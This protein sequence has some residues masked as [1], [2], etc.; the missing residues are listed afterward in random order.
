MIAFGGEALEPDTAKRPE[1][2]VAKT[3]IGNAIF[4][5][6]RSKP[7]AKAAWE[8]YRG[9]MGYV[10]PPV[11]IRYQI[12]KLSGHQ[13]KGTMEQMSFFF[14]RFYDDEIAAEFVS[15]WEK[16]LAEGS[17]TAG[18]I[19]DIQSTLK[20]TRVLMRP[21]LTQKLRALA[22]LS[23]LK[24]VLQGEQLSALKKDVVDIEN[25]LQSAFTKVAQ[26]DFVMDSTK[27]PYERL[28]RHLKDLG[29]VMTD[30]D[31]R[32]EPE[33][34][35]EI[36]RQ[37]RSA[38]DKA[39]DR[40]HAMKALQRVAQL[41]L[42]RKQAIEARI[43]AERRKAQAIEQQ[44]KAAEELRLVQEKAKRIQLEQKRSL[45]ERR[46]AELKIKRRRLEAERR[47]KKAKRERVKA[48]RERVGAER[49]RV[50]KEKHRLEAARRARTALS[51]ARTARD[52]AAGLI[53]FPHKKIKS[54]LAQQ[55]L[56]WKGTPYRWGGETKVRGTD[57]SGFTQGVSQESFSA[58]L[59]RTSRLQAV[60]GIPVA[61]ND[62]QAGDLVFFATGRNPRKVTHVGIFLGDGR[63]AHASSSRGVVDDDFNKNY[64]RRRYLRARRFI[65][66]F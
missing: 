27:P 62:L 1:I 34:F 35:R 58:R 11:A 33:R 56:T 66:A 59:P 36:L 15:Y 28:A 14:E 63:F 43:D 52:N 51:R 57:C 48:E 25:E 37:K 10:P 18:E 44:K 30:S 22:R 3:R 4:I 8:A 29:Q 49:R 26:S 38:K 45:A 23:T 55:Y 6:V 21:L 17:A 2:G 60:H 20:K 50:Q 64:Y 39:K 53:S 9:V 12:A 5:G 42:E 41:E 16:R 31:L 24:L 32:L 46:K 19:A 61:K 47:Q 65:A 13:P 54:V 40:A 7:G